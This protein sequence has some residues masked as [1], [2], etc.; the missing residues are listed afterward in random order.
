VD[1]HF[2]SCFGLLE[3]TYHMV[4]DASVAVRTIASVDVA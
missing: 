2:L 3:Q 1:A 4:Q